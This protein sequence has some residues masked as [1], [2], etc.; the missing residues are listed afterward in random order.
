MCEP[1]YSNQY[2]SVET[3]SNKHPPSL[4]KPI[5]ITF[6]ENIPVGF[7]SI[8]N[9]QKNIN[10]YVDNPSRRVCHLTHSFCNIAKSQVI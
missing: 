10:F 4:K 5:D 7:E 9:K 6:I 2:N 3:I 1:S 8:G